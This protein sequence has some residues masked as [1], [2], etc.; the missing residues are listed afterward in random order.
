M[1]ERVNGSPPGYVARQSGGGGRG[2]SRRGGGFGVST[3]GL[4]GLPS[5]VG[6]PG[7]R[8]ARVDENATLAEEGGGGG[9]GRGRQNGEGEA[10]EDGGGGGGDAEGGGLG[11]TRES[12]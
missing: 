10:D 6:V 12:V 4:G 2:G 9:G 1:N 3:L 7:G 11:R 5:I 8:L